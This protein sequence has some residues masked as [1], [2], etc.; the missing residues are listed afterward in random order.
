MT[1]TTTT[2]TTTTRKKGKVDEELGPVAIFDVDDGG[3]DGDDGNVEIWV[4]LVARQAMS[5]AA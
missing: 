2:T 5:A 3:D 4:I 1:T